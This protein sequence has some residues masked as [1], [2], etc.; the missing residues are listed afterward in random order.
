MDKEFNLALVTEA[1]QD[2][3]VA[4]GVRTGKKKASGSHEAAFE[5]LAAQEGDAA[6]LTG[7]RVAF[8]SALVELDAGRPPPVAVFCRLRE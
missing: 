1:R 8:G 6:G 4:G 2:V 3:A 5:L 7:G